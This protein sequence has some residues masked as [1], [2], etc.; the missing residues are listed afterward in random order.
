MCCSDATSRTLYPSSEMLFNLH[1]TGFGG[2]DSLLLRLTRIGVGGH[3][4]WAEQG[5]S[6]NSP[7]SSCSRFSRIPLFGVVPRPS[8]KAGEG[9]ED[10]GR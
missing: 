3:W 5:Q 4:G 10:G 9:D 1:S 2:F 8:A 7:H 6:S